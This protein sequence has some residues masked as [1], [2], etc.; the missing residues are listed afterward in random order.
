M[1]KSQADYVEVLYTNAG[2]LGLG[3][4]VGHVNIYP[5]GGSRQPGCELKTMMEKFKN[6]VSDAVFNW[7]GK[8]RGGM[9]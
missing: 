7:V 3:W 5:H 6:H 2:T 9:S 4:P 1:D 8:Y